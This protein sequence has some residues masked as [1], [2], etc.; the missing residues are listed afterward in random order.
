MKKTILVTMPLLLALAACT[1]S[2]SDGEKQGPLV[3]QSLGFQKPAVGPTLTESQI[4]EMKSTLKSESKMILPPGELVFPDKN[5]SPEERTQKEQEL[6][7]QDPNAYKLMIEARKNC[8]LVHPNIKLDTTFPTENLDNDNAFD[9]LQKGDHLSFNTSGGLTNKSNCP[10]DAGASA[11]VGAEVHE[12]NSA[13]RSGRA[14]AGIGGKL[15]FVMKN[16]QYAN[17]LGTRGIIVDTNISGVAV[18]KEVNGKEDSGLLTYT[19]SG[20]YLSLKA[21]IPYNIDVKVLARGNDKGD[22]SGEITFTAKLTYPTFTATLIGHATGTGEQGT[23]EFYL[24]G[25]PVSEAELQQIFGNELPG[26]S[27]QKTL[28]KALLN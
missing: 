2:S 17:L 6:A 8:G 9:I 3:P 20:S 25:R 14:S 13:D 27:T 10:V 22:S 21:D 28:K 5:M 24:N 19:L 18:H 23:K 15:K 26:E 1:S 16:P 7:Q 11:G 12:V 4:A